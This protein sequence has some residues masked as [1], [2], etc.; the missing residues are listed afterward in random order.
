MTNEAHCSPSLAR[1]R[2]RCRGRMLSLSPVRALRPVRHR[3]SGP[4]TA[5]AATPTSAISSRCCP[6]PIFPAM[7]IRNSS[8]TAMTEEITSALAKVPDLRVVAR[9]SAFQFKGEN[10]RHAGGRRRRWAQ[11]ISSKA[12]CA[13]TA[14]GCASPRSSSRPITACISGPRTTT[15]SSRDI[16]A[17]QEDIATAIAGACGCRSAWRRASVSSPTAPSIRNPISNISAPRRW[18]ARGAEESPAAIKILEPLVAR[19]PD[20]APAWAL[21]AAGLRFDAELQPQR[22]PS[23]SCAASSMNIFRRRRR[24]HGGQSNW[25]PISQTDT[26]PWRAC[27]S[28]RGKFLLAEEL[29]SKA[30]ALDPNN[31]DALIGY[32]NLLADVGRLKEALAM[33][34]QLRALEPF[35]PR[36]T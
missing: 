12:R 26:W 9:T 35:V 13:R 6:L 8:P 3:Q 21:L 20:Y 11:R 24:Q 29:L 4:R 17:I 31:P 2:P 18:C 36:L 30:L 14:T 28:S 1:R 32:S 34:Q 5:V 22:A 10:Q 15:A 25:I 23:T 7:R 33:R 16:F 27:R 19:N